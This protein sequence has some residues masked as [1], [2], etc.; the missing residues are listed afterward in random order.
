MPF[1]LEVFFTDDVTIMSSN[2]VRAKTERQ[3]DRDSK[4]KGVRKSTSQIKGMQE[5][6]C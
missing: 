6:N 2:P 5:K 1:V 4:H 3:M